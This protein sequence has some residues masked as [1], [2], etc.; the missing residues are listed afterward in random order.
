MINNNTISIG[1]L[2]PIIMVT[3]A[4]FLCKAN[5]NNHDLENHQRQ[6]QQQQHQLKKQRGNVTLVCWLCFSSKS[7]LVL[8]VQGNVVATTSLSVC[9]SGSNYI[10]QVENYVT[11]SSGTIASGCC[12]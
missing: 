1:C 9:C 2:Q 10:R 11:S 3:L 8:M 5:N 4:C 7:W 6:Q 12:V